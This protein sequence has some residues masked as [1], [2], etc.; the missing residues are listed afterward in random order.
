M[1][2]NYAALKSLFHY[3]FFEHYRKISAKFI[4]VF[5]IKQCVGIKHIR[6]KILISRK[7]Q[8]QT[9]II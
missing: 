1:P 5:R 7:H 2:L 4:Y 6:G 9:A 8:P 3:N